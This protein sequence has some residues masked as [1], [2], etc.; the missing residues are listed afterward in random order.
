MNNTN[1]VS[2]SSYSIT[3]ASY[4]VNSYIEE[5]F[6]DLQIK[7]LMVDRR[8]I[9]ESGVR[10]FTEEND[11]GK[12]KLG[13][14][15]KQLIKT[16]WDAIVGIFKKLRDFFLKIKNKIFGKKKQ[17]LNTAQDKY[18]LYK[19]NQ[20]ELVS[21]MRDLDDKVFRE[22]IDKNV[23]KYYDIN[24]IDTPMD[25]IM[26]IS[27]FIPEHNIDKASELIDRVHK[28]LSTPLP[29]VNKSSITKKIVLICA[30]GEFAYSY[31][32]V[33][34]RLESFKKIIDPLLEHSDE[35]DPQLL[36]LV[37][38]ALKL[39]VSFSQKYSTIMIHNTKELMKV[40]HYI[41][42]NY[43]RNGVSVKESVDWSSIL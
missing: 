19:A 37:K 39:I 4:I 16:V 7:C 30:F 5:S 31:R 23:T 12:Q 24:S 29:E 21:Y 33:N 8:S 6:N 14:K 41:Y 38:D 9:Q 13:E 26:D 15:I 25:W 27:L 10:Y 20:K 28:F 36:P 22:A 2:F 32:S 42:N 40:V 34:S 17:E 18:G 3:E 35:L 43:D 1:N 11:T